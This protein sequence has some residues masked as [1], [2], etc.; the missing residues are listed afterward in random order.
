MK[1]VQYI[2]KFKF[3][4]KNGNIDE[5]SRHNFYDKNSRHKNIDEISRHSI[6]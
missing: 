3:G 4:K 6:R 2:Q 1:K 5:I